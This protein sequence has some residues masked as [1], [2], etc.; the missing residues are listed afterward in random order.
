VRCWNYSRLPGA[1]SGGGRCRRQVQKSTLL[2]QRFRSKIGCF[3]RRRKVVP[4]VGNR[5]ND[6]RRV[7]SDKSIRGNVLGEYGTRRNNRVFAHRHSADDRCAGCDP[8]VSSNH[9]GLCDYEGAPPRRFDGMARRDDAHVRP[10]HHIVGNVETCACRKLNP[11]ILVMHSAQDWATK[12]VPG[13]I[14]GT[15]D[16]RIFLQG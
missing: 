15:L 3:E 14:D 9:D 5:T 8:N 6:P 12:N 4:S 13:A 7:S 1:T 16:R 11:G 2:Q 10:D